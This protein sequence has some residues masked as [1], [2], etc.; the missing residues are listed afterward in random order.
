[1]SEI[2]TT[3]HPPL[4]RMTGITKRFGP[5]TVLEGVDF[6]VRAGE[7]HILA[8][9][10]GAGKSTLI[11]ILAG[12]HTDFVGQIEIQGRTVRPANPLDA[13]RLG[14]AVIHQELS[15]VPSMSV[16]DNIF[17][18]RMLTTRGGLVRDAAQRAET[19]RMLDQFGLDLPADRRVETLP[20]AQQ[21]LVE[22]AKA[23]SLE[24]KVLV[25]DE[26]TSALNA[27][28]VER[29][30]GLIQHLKNTGCGIV[31]ITHKMEEIERIA[32]RIT[33]LRD[34]RRIGSA[35]AGQLP[36]SRLIHW[37]VGREVDQQYPR[38]TTE[39]GGGRLRIER[40]GL[41]R[42]RRLLVD[43]VS[44][45][46]RA[47]EIVGLAGLQGSGNSD[48]LMGLF[49]G[50]GR[51]RRGRCG[52]TI[53]P[54]ARLSPPFDRCG[55]GVADQRSQGQ[56]A[57]PVAVDRRQ[58]DTRPTGPVLARRLA[59]WR[60]GVGGDGEDRADAGAARRALDMEVGN[61][62]G[63]N[64]QK[65]ALAKWILTRPR[66]LLLDEPTRGVDVGAKREIY[67]LMN[68]WTAQGIAILLVTSEMPELLAL[69]DRIVVMHRGRVTRRF[70]RGEASA[71]RV[72]EAAMG[73]TTAAVHVVTQMIDTKQS[74]KQAWMRWIT[75]PVGRALLAL[76]MILV[77]GIVFHADGAFFKIGTHRDALRQASVYGMLACG[78][79][80]VI[81]AG[82]SICRS[83]ACWRWSPSASAC[84][85]ST[86]VGR[87]GWASRRP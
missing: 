31:Y 60:A 13:A 38:H 2:G 69:S 49:G 82:G 72:L 41:R 57:G 59:P 67:A 1:M 75:G 48:L 55:H 5:V 21:Q 10:N 52:W 4:V 3:G 46:V 58:H 25:M 19:Q 29:L 11:K 81:I 44:L 50:Y 32:D 26:P 35:P 51:V 80:L 33:V 14:V 36:I 37:M 23:L 63:G 40:F 79:T 17:L 34:G 73:A 77:L 6:E 74:A 47:G 78:M 20:V 84:C 61:L 54:S 86:G 28:E 87:P 56:R 71:E 30:F 45:E 22:I 76:A 15:L 65:V 64:Q 62:S 85:R 68:Q 42:G 66:V 16:A 27:P 43:D 8:G 9:E 12:V 83:A 53:G 70:A 18:G 7:V 24:A 39:P